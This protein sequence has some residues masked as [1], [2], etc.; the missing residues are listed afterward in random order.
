MTRSIVAILRGI[1]PE[2]ALPIAEGL[3]DAG[4]TMIEVPLNSPR[5][6]VSIRAMAEAF[7][8]R[9]L[10]GAGT[11]LSVDDVKDLRAAGGQ[12]VVSPDMNP[13]VIE[14]SK[15]LGMVSYPGVMT[16]TECFAALR[17]GADGLKLFPGS[18]IGPAGL[19]AMRAVIPA[20][21]PVFAVGGASPAN[22]AEWFAAGA[23]GFGIGTALYR[24]GDT[25]DLV[26]QRAR[27][28][29][30]AYDESAPE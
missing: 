14:A 9:A 10:I 3:I 25:A 11:V 30:A 19:K 2:D 12:L 8:D 17:A 1:T 6:M 15:A 20:K 24:P 26:I 23:D 18:L 7:H 22:F 16:P 27:E 29:V 5:P 28:I 21:V 13:Q 4:I